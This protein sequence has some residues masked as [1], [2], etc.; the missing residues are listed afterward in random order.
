M[1][2]ATLKLLRATKTMCQATN[3]KLATGHTK[4]L[5]DRKKYV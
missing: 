4:Y 5:K 2:L 3:L 1:S